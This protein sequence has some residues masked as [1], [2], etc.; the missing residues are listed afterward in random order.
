MERGVFKVE[1]E[2][3]L[4]KCNESEK[5]KCEKVWGAQKNIFWNGSAMG[6]HKN[7]KTVL[8]EKPIFEKM[9]VV[10]FAKN[11]NPKDS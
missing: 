2:E 3:F 8:P 1:K 5:N 9:I 6:N 7:E 11:G 4:K 10:I